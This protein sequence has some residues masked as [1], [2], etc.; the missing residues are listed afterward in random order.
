MESITASY[1]MT[2]KAPWIIFKQYF[3]KSMEFKEWTFTDFDDV[4][5]GNPLMAAHPDDKPKE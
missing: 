4:L 2:L 3:K 5:K 1:P